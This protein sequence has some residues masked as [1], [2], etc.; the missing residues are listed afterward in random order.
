ME[1]SSN[2]TTFRD[3]SEAKGYLESRFKQEVAGCR[4]DVSPDLTQKFEVFVEQANAGIVGI[5]E[6][7]KDITGEKLW[8]E[9]LGQIYRSSEFHREL[10]SG[11]AGNLEKELSDADSSAD[12]IKLAGELAYVNGG[13]IQQDLLSGDSLIVSDAGVRELVDNLFLEQTEV[14]VELVKLLNDAREYVSLNQVEGSFVLL[15]KVGDTRLGFGVEVDEDGMLSSVGIEEITAA[16]RSY[17]FDRTV[18]K[19]PEVNGGAKLLLI[20]S[21]FGDYPGYL[22]D[23]YS[24]P[25]DLFLL[26]STCGR[27]WVP[28]HLENT[29]VGQEIKNKLVKTSALQN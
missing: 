1:N 24:L 16:C 6:I 12:I 17:K 15:K 28:M 9:F 27:N 23:P 13:G 26:K 14:D 7:P 2:N 29:K 18:E 11:V 21:K 20:S 3:L 25:A 4:D 19:L 8:K 5:E 22:H 10:I